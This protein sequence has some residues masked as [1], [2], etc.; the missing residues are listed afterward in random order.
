MSLSATLE[1]IASH[2][3]SRA[4]RT[5]A[6]G[7]L[8]GWQLRSRLSREVTVN[9]I[10]GSKLVVRNGMHGATGNI[11]CGL[12]EFPEMAFLLHL[13]RPAD[14]FLNIGANVGSFTV[15][16]AKVCESRVIAFE[17]DPGTAA[18]LRKNITVNQVVDQVRVE[19]CA[20][21]DRTGEAAFTIGRDVTNHIT[22]GSEGPTQLV[23]IRRLDDICAGENPVLIKI[24]VEGFESQVL[25]GGAKV[26]RCKSLMAVES[27]SDH[28]DIIPVM[29]DAGFVPRYYDP[30]ARTL[31]STPGGY[32]VTNTIFVRES[33]ELVD[34]LKSA[35]RRTVCGVEF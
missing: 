19:V 28:G 7:R 24:D 12:N 26:L 30:F 11:Y 3:L 21:G 27:E 25:A 33:A 8:L 5:A 31:S 34:R 16:G 6:F 4:N 18:S 20:L 29:A 15:L 22:D 1:F 35:P 13:L 14:L 32:K 23:P 17:P 9:W 10:A 2:P